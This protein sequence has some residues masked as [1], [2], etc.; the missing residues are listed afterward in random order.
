MVEPYAFRALVLEHARV[1]RSA[2]EGLPCWSEDLVQFAKKCLLAD[3]YALLHNRRT[4]RRF[5]IRRDDQF[6]PK[7]IFILEP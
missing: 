6:D 7:G 5:R 4:N 3:R 2:R 1:G